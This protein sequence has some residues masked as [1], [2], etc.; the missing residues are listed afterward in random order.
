MS[1]QPIEKCVLAIDPGSSKCGVAVVFR[2]TGGE[3][4]IGWR[5]VVQASELEKTIRAQRNLHNIS[6][7][8]IGSG[9]RGRETSQRLQTEFPSAGVLVIDEQNT[10]LQARE[11]YWE[12]HPRKGWRRFLPSSMQVPPEPYDDFVAVILAERVLTQ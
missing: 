10:T 6:L 4:T 3:I 1:Q 5:E 11:R 7:I 12:S 9:T 2:R 8:I